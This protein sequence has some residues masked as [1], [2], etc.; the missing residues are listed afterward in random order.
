MAALRPTGINPGAVSAYY[1]N[2]NRSIEEEEENK[3][4]IEENL[5]NRISKKLPSTKIN[6]ANT[7]AKMSIGVEKITETL[8]NNAAIASVASEALTALTAASALTSVGRH[9]KTQNQQ[10]SYLKNAANNI[11]GGITPSGA[12]VNLGLANH[13]YNSIKGVAG[14]VGTASA[15]HDLIGGNF[16]ANGGMSGTT[17]M[18]YGIANPAFGAITALGGFGKVG[19]GIN[20]MAT[21][22]V[23]GGINAGINATGT[24]ALL[25]VGEKGVNISG[26]MGAGNMAAGMDL[27]TGGIGFFALNKAMG[28][29]TDKIK[30]MDP[31]NAKN[32]KKTKFS[33]EFRIHRYATEDPVESSEHARNLSFIKTLG[34]NGMGVL[35]VAESMQ[36]SMLSGIKFNTS[37]MPTLT[38]MI[39]EMQ[40]NTSPNQNRGNSVLNSGI[41]TF[42]VQDHTGKEFDSL[43]RNGRPDTFTKSLLGVSNFFTQLSTLNPGTLATNMFNRRD[44]NNTAW[45]LRD[46]EMQGDLLAADKK[47]AQAFGL[48]LSDSSLLL[49]DLEGWIATQDDKQL[50]LA[51]YQAK[52]TRIQTEKIVELVKNSGGKDGKKESLGSLKER[53]NLEQQMKAQEK[54]SFLIDS[55]LRSMDDTLRT[56]PVLKVLS[57]LLHLGTQAGKGLFNLTKLDGSDIKNYFGSMY[58][59]AKDSFISKYMDPSVKNETDLRNA[60]GLNEVSLEE[61]FYSYMVNVFPNEFQKLLKAVGVKDAANL[62]SDKYS[63]DWVS[64]QELKDRNQSKMDKLRGLLTSEMP[65]EESVTGWLKDKV[66][67]KVFGIKDMGAS[68]EDLA[69]KNFG[70]INDMT[71][72]INNDDVSLN[73][74]INSEA[75]KKKRSGK[76]GST[77]GN[78]LSRIDENL[79]KLLK[80]CMELK[81]LQEGDTKNILK[82]NVQ[83]SLNAFARNKHKNGSVTELSNQRIEKDRI[84]DYQD[85]TKNN[86]PY[87]EKIYTLLEDKFKTGPIKNK[88]EVKNEDFGDGLFGG[89]FDS[90]G[91]WFGFGDKDKGKGK[92]KGKGNWLTKIGG[93][94]KHLKSGLSLAGIATLFSSMGAAVVAGGSL[95][96]AIAVPIAIAAVVGTAGYL[97]YDNWES[98]KNSLNSG[99]EWLKNSG[100]K[101]F[102]WIADKID[103]ISEKYQGFKDWL[104]GTTPNI[105]DEKFNNTNISK[106]DDILKNGTTAQ[107]IAE[108]DRMANEKT[109]QGTTKEVRDYANLKRKELIEQLNQE[110]YKKFGIDVNSHEMLNYKDQI[111]NLSLKGS[112]DLL[113]AFN[114]QNLADINIGT[115]EQKI[116]DTILTELTNQ[117]IKAS[118]EEIKISKMNDKDKEEYRK[119][120]PKFD[121]LLEQLQQMNIKIDPSKSNQDLLNGIQQISTANIGGMSSVAQSIQEVATA[122]AAVSVKMMEKTTNKMEFIL[123]TN[124]M[125]LIPGL[126]RLGQS[127]NMI[128]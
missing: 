26:M 115:E 56:I 112:V 13:S 6:L 116:R 31:N 78:E 88:E 64:A 72:A 84:K 2:S 128:K 28:M 93:W 30:S 3:R 47:A 108:L 79:A 27:L 76:I 54:H 21:P 123:N 91:G 114:M 8:K 14:T 60:V 73:H 39:E 113:S 25:G 46:A 104:T 117:Q 75:F 118:Q 57:P 119:L 1:Q 124:V 49:A 99:Y 4:Q 43:L 12:G 45:N 7:S 41:D 87:L 100:G 11:Y 80:C 55:V 48:S 62:V 69:T 40:N 110:S 15:L 53:L 24:S 120:N 9:A 97:I 37:F 85:I 111:K 59:D 74:K 67:R 38:N 51:Y 94:L 126:S 106:I 22:L 34:P 81:A 89:L 82:D 42:G 92:G 36:L 95:L 122:T 71:E 32:V 61:R 102:D 70:Y 16:L 90:I 105:P 86:L 23:N 20:A 18:A 77:S 103:W 109:T 44:I 101:G 35:S 10:N 66:G 125:E 65:G 83:N 52:L 98:I 96:A 68:I 17:K 29:I 50:A 107:K 121:S 63:T 19:A 33:T 127:S 58:K 5:I